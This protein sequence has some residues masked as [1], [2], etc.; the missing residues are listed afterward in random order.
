MTHFTE[1]LER[2]EG[3]ASMSCMEE[4]ETLHTYAELLQE[5]ERWKARFD[6]FQ[7]RAGAVI[8]LCADHSMPAT[9]VLLA[10]FARHAVAALVPRDRDAVR[11]LRA[12]FAEGFLDL[13]VDGTYSWQTFDGPASHPLLEDLRASKDG[14]LV[15]FTSGSTGHPKA[16]LHSTERIL[17]KFS[18]RCR[19][20]RTLAFLLFDHVAG[21]DTLFYALSGGSTL[22]LTR[23][24]DPKTILTIIASHRVEVLPTSPS[25]LR[26]LCI[27]KDVG[28]QDLSSLRIIT[29]GSEPMDANTLARLNLCFPHVQITQKY[30]S[31]EMGSPRSISRGSDSLWIKIDSQDVEAKVVNGV[32]WLRSTS[33]IL[34]YLNAPQPLNHDGWYCTGDLVDVDG[35]WMRFRGRDADIINVGGEKV[36]PTEVEESILEL[37]FVRDVVVAGEPHALLGQIVAARV[38]LATQLDP[39]EAARRI[40]LHCRDRLAAYKVPVRIDCTAEPFAN[41]RQKMQ[42]HTYGSNIPDEHD[43]AGHKAGDG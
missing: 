11:Y 3:Y 30:G 1:L 22:I 26:M 2:L 36:A 35:E 13:D 10:L 40:R 27:A 37:D 28:Q 23:Y 15:L 5:Y 43:A 39:K 19:R 7:V 34:G 17:R 29:Y 24:R 41:D 14:G 8:G 32:L 21:F 4:G 38:A 16:A 42:R 25:F 6:Q 18:K 9:A 31:T 12:A 20:F 33:A